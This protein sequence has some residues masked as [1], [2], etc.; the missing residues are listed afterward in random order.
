MG[1]DLL[2]KLAEKKDMTR[3]SFMKEMQNLTKGLSANV[4]SE[5]NFETGEL[6]F[7]IK[8]S[9]MKEL[10]EKLEALSEDENKIE[11]IYR[12]LDEQDIC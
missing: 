11:R 9:G 5:N 12:F 10:K 6:T 7:S 8:A 1:P 2:K 3:I 4:F